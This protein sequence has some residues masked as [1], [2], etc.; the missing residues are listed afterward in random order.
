MDARNGG[1]GGGV[2]IGGELC[3][4]LNATRT[5]AMACAGFPHAGGEGEVTGRDGNEEERGLEGRI[6]IAGG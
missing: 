3:G 5:Q 1:V 6:G 2:G 4:W